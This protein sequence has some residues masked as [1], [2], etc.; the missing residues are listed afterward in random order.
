MNAVM[1]FAREYSALARVLEPRDLASLVVA[2]AA[3]APEILKSRKLTAVDAAM[4]RDITIHFDGRPLAMPL[5]SIDRI[6]AAHNDNPTFGNVR[7]LYA[8]NCYLKHLRFSSPQ[9]TV[10]DLGANRGMFS[11]LAFVALGAELVVGVEP[12]TCYLPVCETLLK[13]NR[14]DPSRAPRYNKFIAPLSAER[15][16]P[17]RNISILTILEE[18]KID[19][20]NLVKI[21]IEGA[22]ES[23]FAEPQWLAR[24]DTLT[25]ELHPAF[26]GDLS[27]IPRALERYGFAF[28]LMDKFGRP[29]D[30]RSAMFLIASRVGALAV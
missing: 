2:T 18:Q 6:L 26:A 3:C 16:D 1:R 28:R 21:D 30:I 13:A 4:S 24:V 11:V 9:R 23:M 5:R 8:R 12:A 14:C 19:H 25:M 7:E 29:A 10:L 27:C 17:Q 15:A 20:F 22:E